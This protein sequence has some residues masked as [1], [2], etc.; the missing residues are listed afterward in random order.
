MINMKNKKLALMSAIMIGTF[1]LGAFGTAT[2][3]S[4]ADA[5][6][7]V[8]FSIVVETNVGN[9]LRESIAY[10]LQQAL[11]PLGIDVQVRGVPFSQFVGDLLFADPKPYDIGIVGFAGGSVF[12]P[13]WVDLYV[14]DP[15]IGFFGP[16]TYQL[17]SPVWKDALA[18][19]TANDIGLTQEMV[20]NL[21]MNITNNISDMDKR[22]EDT[23]KFQEWFMNY[24]LYD[25]PLLAP[26]GVVSVWHGF[27]GYDPDEGSVNSAFLGAQWNSSTPTDRKNNATTIA[28]SIA[29]VSGNFDPLQIAD[30]S[31]GT[32][33]ANLFPTLLRFSGKDFSPHPWLAKSFNIS[34]WEDAPIGE[35]GTTKDVVAGKVKFYLNTDW[36]WLNVTSGQ[37]VG[38]VTVD[39]VAFTLE[40]YRSPHIVINGK[41]SYKFIEMVETN[42]TEQSITLY[43]SQPNLED[44]RAFGGFDIIPKS[45][46]GGDLT[47]SNG[48]TISAVNYGTNSSAGKNI[49]NYN[50]LN[51]EEWN[52]WE[53]N[54]VLQSGP[55]YVNFEDSTMYKVGEF[56]EKRANPFFTFPNE[57]DSTNFDMRTP[58]AEDAFFFA[59][60]DDPNTAGTK[61]KPNKLQIT[62]YKH[63]IVEDI[64][65]QLLLFK[66][67]QLD[68]TNPTS[69]GGDELAAQQNDPRFD[70]FTGLA[71]VATADLLIFDL[72]N[73]H[74]KK[75][76]VRRAI[77][78]AIDKEG[79]LSNLFDNLRKPQDSPV[80]RF[81]ENVDTFKDG[82]RGWYNDT[83]KIPFNLTE[84]KNLMIAAGYKIQSA[85][86]SN[87]SQQ[88]SSVVQSIQSSVA[89]VVNEVVSSV[90]ADAPT[91][92]EAFVA[93][94]VLVSVAVGFRRKKNR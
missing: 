49:T 39:D 65:V 50:P 21:L 57:W 32:A 62:V 86:F 85:G 34:T 54:P 83:W 61:E 75:Y 92:F 35:N 43:V 58:A 10:Y 74:I 19:D 51:T 47:F 44:L 59:Y 4:P 37:T 40:I 30:T 5:Q 91:P 88:V 67:G 12:A 89:T 20:D 90:I 36:K 79:T 80:S 42:S 56:V 73:E 72:K 64:N 87:P 28:T 82:K 7:L 63:P 23:N 41:S 11:A 24:L 31:T 66:D 17:N 53:K 45:L 33:V 2:T 14:S 8:N 27:E 76:N 18:N 84:A 25:Y 15:A 70:V 68:F 77:A 48:T 94:V 52:A 55:Y 29:S 9:R 26:S 60:A 78:H 3:Y 71:V 1:I 69:F 38:S 81:F 6:G 93:S 46:L 16:L 22:Y 13:D